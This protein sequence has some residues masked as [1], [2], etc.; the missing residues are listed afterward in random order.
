MSGIEDLRNKFV[1]GNV[2]DRD[3]GDMKLDRD[4]IDNYLLRMGMSPLP[5]RLSTGLFYTPEE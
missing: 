2:I 3:F 5:V 4:T 1:D